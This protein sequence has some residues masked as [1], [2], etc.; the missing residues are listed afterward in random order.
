MSN[1]LIAGFS[2]LLTDGG[3]TVFDGESGNFEGQDYVVLYPD[4]GLTS[5]DWETLC[6]SPDGLVCT[7]RTTC[8]GMTREQAGATADAV[9]ALVSG[10]RVGPVTGFQVSTIRNLITRLAIR[11]DDADPAVFYAVTDWRFTAVSVT[12]D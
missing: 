5:E 12:A 6:G 9:R 1:P 11:D 7:I 2:K 10:K 8:V 3:L 4:S